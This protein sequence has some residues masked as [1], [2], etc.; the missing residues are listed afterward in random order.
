MKKKIH[1]LIY[2][3]EEE[4]NLRYNATNWGVCCLSLGIKLCWASLGWCGW[5]WIMKMMKLESGPIPKRSRSKIQMWNIMFL[6]S[7]FYVFSFLLVKMCC[8]HWE[9]TYIDQNSSDQTVL[10]AFEKM[11]FRD[12]FLAIFIVLPV[13]MEVGWLLKFVIQ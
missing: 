8:L 3:R 1:G 5:D 11:V 10:W 13:L 6:S 4:N 2:C 12:Q 9:G 7:G